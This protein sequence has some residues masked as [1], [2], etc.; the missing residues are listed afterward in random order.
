MYGNRFSDWRMGR[1]PTDPLHPI[2]SFPAVMGRTYSSFAPFYIFGLI[3]MILTVELTIRW[4]SITAIYSRDTISREILSESLPIIVIKIASHITRDPFRVFLRHSH[5]GSAHV[6]IPARTSS[7]H[8]QY[9]CAALPSPT[10]CPAV[11]G[12]HR[13]QELCQPAYRLRNTRKTRPISPGSSRHPH[14]LVKMVCRN[15]VGSTLM[16]STPSDRI[17]TLREALMTA[18]IN[19]GVLLYLLNTRPG[20]SSKVAG[21]EVQTLR[22]SRYSHFQKYPFVHL[23]QGCRRRGP[24][25]QDLL[26]TFFAW[27]YVCCQFVH[28]PDDQ[29]QRPDIHASGTGGMVC[30]DPATV[31]IKDFL[32]GG[33]AF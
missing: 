24:D 28:D 12:D 9:L 31:C 23:F 29:L 20:T 13:L 1:P 17:F 7:A 25:Y 10:T 8:P 33:T 21:V 15:L 6:P 26:S 32:G 11:L 14:F 22:S 16:P 5:P 27:G 4:N 19:E 18:S 2:V 3:H 30:D